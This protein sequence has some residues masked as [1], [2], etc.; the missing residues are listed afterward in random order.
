MDSVSIN[1]ELLR[2]V[3]LKKKDKQTIYCNPKVT[4]FEPPNIADLRKALD[5]LRNIITDK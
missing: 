5:N 3:K 2:S 1:S 4:S